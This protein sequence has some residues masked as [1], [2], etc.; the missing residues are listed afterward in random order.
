MSLDR[1]LPPD[2]STLAE[3]YL[4]V[5]DLTK[6]LSFLANDFGIVFTIL[7]SNRS[8]PRAPT[9]DSWSKTGGTG[10]SVVM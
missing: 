1:S 5:C 2:G 4:E 7:D 9:R 10:V 8:S 6:P 3:T